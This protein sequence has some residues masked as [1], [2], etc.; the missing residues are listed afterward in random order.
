MKE[1]IMQTTWMIIALSSIAYANPIVIEDRL[2]KNQES[3][4]VAISDSVANVSCSV[5]YH[6]IGTAVQ[7]YYMNVPVFVSP[8]S[9][10]NSKDLHSLIGMRLECEGSSV[11]FRGVVLRIPD[12]ELPPLDNKGDQGSKT[13]MI[14][15]FCYEFEPP[16]Q[17]EFTVVA[18]YKQPL[19]DDSAYYLPLFEY[20]E[21][22]GDKENFTIT[23]FSLNDSELELMTSHEDRQKVMN[24]R[25]TVNPIHNETIS[26]RTKK[27]ENKAEMATPRKPS[28]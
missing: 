17:D 16:D 5:N 4:V 26:V 7:K 24:S 2:Q 6:K 20:G 13:P 9:D 18:S 19:I 1:I 15:D 12:G 3:C 14:I 10:H 11:V 8:T 21:V 27:R 23:F 28:D 25:I 22:D